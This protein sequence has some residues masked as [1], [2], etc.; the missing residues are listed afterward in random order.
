MENEQ[1]LKIIHGDV[2]QCIKEVGKANASI[3]INYLRL[4]KIDDYVVKCDDRLADLEL[5]KARQEGKSEGKKSRFEMLN[6]KTVLICTVGALL[7]SVLAF[8]FTSIKPTVEVTAGLIK[9]VDTISQNYERV[10]SQL[11]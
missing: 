5:S 9:K 7:I 2:I 4:T 11:D 8:Y 10:L 3:K 6:S 1:F